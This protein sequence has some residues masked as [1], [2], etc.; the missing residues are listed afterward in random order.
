LN[1]FYAHNR[2]HSLDS[3]YVDGISITIGSSRKHV[4][5]YTAGRSDNYDYGVYKLNCPCSTYPGYCS[6][7]F[8]KDNYYCE[9]GVVGD[10]NANFYYLSNPLWDGNGCTIGSA[11]CAQIGMPWFYR[12]LPVPVND[13]FEVRM[14][15]DQEHANEDIAVEKLEI[16]VID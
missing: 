3:V 13:D 9:S 14:C 8:V 10:S 16:F 12:R 2:S 11:C 1:A 4:W 7:E 5:T 15:K 6:P